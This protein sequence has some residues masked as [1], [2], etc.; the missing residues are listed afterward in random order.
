MALHKIHN[1]TY[2]PSQGFYAPS[3]PTVL[4]FNYTEK[5]LECRINISL[6]CFY[7]KEDRSSDVNSR[8]IFLCFSSSPCCSASFSPHLFMFLIFNFLNISSMLPLSACRLISN[9]ELNVSG[10]LVVLKF[11][12]NMIKNKSIFQLNTNSSSE[13]N[14]VTSTRI[15]WH[16]MHQ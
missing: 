12:V 3:S 9:R 4:W 8:Y 7:L 5:C 11:R 14:Y 6:F 1:M 10:C 15:I 2:V 13:V 16:S